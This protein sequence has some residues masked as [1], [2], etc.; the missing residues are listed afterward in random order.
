MTD[1]GREGT[2]AASVTDIPDAA[3]PSTIGR[4]SAFLASGTLVSRALGFVS[5]IVLATAIGVNSAAG[6]TFALANQ[7]PNNIY[8]LV[9]GGL[10][11]AVIVPQIVKASLN[12][13]GGAGFINKVITLGLTI[14]VVVTI[15]ATACAPLLIQLYGSGFDEHE[16]ALATALAYWTLPQILFYALYS[17]IGET[18]NAR[19]V[20]GPFTWAPVLNNIVGISGLIVFIALFGSQE[21]HQDAAAWTPAQVALL[22]GSATLGIAVQAFALFFF[23]GRAGLRYRPDF[24]WRGVGLGNT[25]RAA[26]WVF[27]MFLVTQVSGVFEARIASTATGDASVNAMKIAWTMFMLPHSIVTVSIVTAYFTRMSS[28]VRDGRLGELRDDISSALRSILLIMVFSAVGLGVLSFS[29]SSVFGNDYAETSSI[30]QVYLAYLTG[31]IPFTIFFVLLR[32]FYALDRTRAAFVIQVIQTAFYVA[33]AITVGA[34]VP[35]EF[36]AV[37]LA[38][39]LAAAVSLQALLS[40]IYLR[41]A[42]GPLD[43]WRVLRQVLW[44]LAA[45]LV[46]GAV[47]VGVLGALG[48]IGA[49]AFPVANKLTGIL[50]MVIAGAAMAVVYAAVLW[51][52]RNPELRSFGEPILRRLRRAR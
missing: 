34:F 31:L 32:V 9:A 6:D 16:V 23:L 35:K 5:L 10:L 47:G 36:V 46:A 12:N 25:A 38:F 4:A 33:G 2:D 29:F 52:T 15:I 19:G 24:I 42:L 48:G 40:A 27:V 22:A 3:A 39:V 30:A 43:T 17:L 51:I 28:H 18:L 21:Q 14:F 45:A 37:G 26:S 49:G 13:D 50:S 44:F 41:R 20:F 11:S 8:S 1:P 7:L